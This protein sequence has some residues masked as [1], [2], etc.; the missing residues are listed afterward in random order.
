MASERSKEISVT[1]FFTYVL[2]TLKCATNHNAR[3]QPATKL[4]HQSHDDMTAVSIL[5][6]ATI[7]CRKADRGAAWP[8]H[9]RQPPPP[10]RPP[11]RPPFRAAKARA[12]GVQRLQQLQRLEVHAPAST[13]AAGGPGPP[14]APP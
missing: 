4:N 14:L 7:V 12:A 8:N 6:D 1:F 5:H 11:L 2:P 3:P 10:P 13:K 9:Q